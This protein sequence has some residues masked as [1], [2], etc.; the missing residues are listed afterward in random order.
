LLVGKKSSEILSITIGFA[1]FKELPKAGGE[2]LQLSL[3]YIMAH[4]CGIDMSTLT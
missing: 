1:D 2:V 3:A 4:P